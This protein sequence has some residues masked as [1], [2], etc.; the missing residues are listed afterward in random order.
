V[1][2]ACERDLTEARRIKSKKE[3]SER[4]DALRDALIK[5]HF[6]LQP[7][8]TY[9]QYATSLK[10]QTQ[11]KDAFRRLEEKITRRLIVEQRTRADGRGPTEIPPHRVAV[12][13]FQRTHG[14]AFFQR[15]ETQSLV[16][17][18]PGH[19]QG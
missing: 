4:V 3:R 17:L 19:R 6:A 16:L 9:E 13:V 15:G 2:S 14:S 18:H 8:G 11:A 5:N 10:R 7:G 12:G 1:K